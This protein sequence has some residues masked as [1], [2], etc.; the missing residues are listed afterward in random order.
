MGCNFLVDKLGL[1]GAKNQPL[2]PWAPLENELVEREWKTPF[3]LCFL[4]IFFILGEL[5]PGLVLV[6]SSVAKCAYKQHIYRN[7]CITTGSVYVWA[8]SVGGVSPPSLNF[9]HIT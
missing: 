9:A 3:L 1:Y 2:A 5:C 4:S 7:K 8:L 6:S